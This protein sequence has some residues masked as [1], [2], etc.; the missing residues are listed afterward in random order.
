MKTENT[1]QIMPKK[2][3]QSNLEKEWSYDKSDI[4]GSIFPITIMGG[5]ALFALLV[6]ILTMC[7]CTENQ[8]AKS[9]GG[10]ATVDLPPN[11]KFVGATWKEE[12]LWYVYRPSRPGESPEK[13][14]MQEQASF[15]FIQGV[16][17]FQE[18]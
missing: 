7:S 14:T 8:R 17:I 2:S 13:V 4:Q 1:S 6:I 11:T 9:F 16:V 18:K 3:E 15:G 5:A 12:Q 10:T